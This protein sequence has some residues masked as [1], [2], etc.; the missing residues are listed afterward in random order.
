MYSVK[1]VHC[2]KLKKEVKY[3]KTDI[4]LYADI[5]AYTYIYIYI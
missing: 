2:H 5:Y 3:S 1:I 4:I